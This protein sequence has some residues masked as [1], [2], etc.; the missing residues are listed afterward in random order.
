MT[1]IKALRRVGV[2]AAAA[3]LVI[4]VSMKPVTVYAMGTDSP[5]RPTTAARR[6]RKRRTT[7]SS[8]SSNSS[9]PRRNSCATIARPAN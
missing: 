8:S 3:L 4:A 5:P 9:W 6:K 1:L 7:T 2:F